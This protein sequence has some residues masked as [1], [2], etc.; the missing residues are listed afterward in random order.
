VIHYWCDNTRKGRHTC[1]DLMKSKNFICKTL[2]SQLNFSSVEHVLDEYHVAESMF[3]FNY[4]HIYSV[5]NL[6]QCGGL[7]NVLF[8]YFHIYSVHNLM[9]C[10]AR[11]MFYSI[12]SIFTVYRHAI[13]AVWGLVNI[14]FNYF[15]IYSVHIIWCSL[16]LGECSFQLFPYLQCIIWCRVWLGECF[17][18]LF[19]YLQCI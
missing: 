9:Q 3:Y 4:F 13:Y 19:P 6:M 1:F 16:G 18:K 10:G 17:N 8:N 11:W 14:L 12:F 5:H 7:V 2:F 15:H